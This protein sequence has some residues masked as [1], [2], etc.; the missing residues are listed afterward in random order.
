VTPP[1]AGQLS[2][3]PDIKEHIVSIRQLRARLSR[4]DAGMSLIEVIVAFTVFAVV[5]VGMAYS[6]AAMT[7]FSYDS[8]KRETASNLALAELDRVQAISDAFAV[9]NQPAQTTNVNGV[10]YTI[11]TKLT[12]VG[13]DGTT[14][15]SCGTA[16]SGTNLQYKSVNIKVS[17]AGMLNVSAVR[18]DSALAPASRV[19]D[20]SFGTILVN[21]YG[22]DGT[23]RSAVTV[24][25]TPKTGGAAITE[26]IDPTDS[27]GC[28]YVLKVSPGTYTIK[29]SKASYMETKQNASFSVDKPVTAG[30][31][32]T[33]SVEY[34]EQASFGLKYAA[35]VTSPPLLPSGLST[36]YYYGPSTYVSTSTATP[37]KLYPYLNGYSG[38]AG[39]ALSCA[40]SDPVAWP[41]SGSL[42]AGERGTPVAASPGGNAN[43]SVPMGVVSAKMTASGTLIATQQ[44]S[45]P[46]GTPT[47]ATPATLT[48]GAVTS[49]TTYSVALPYGTWKL[50]VKNGT[51]T[52]QITTGITVVGSAIVIDDATGVLGKN[53]PGNSTVTAGV[54]TLDPRGPVS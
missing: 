4:D 30:N 7:R 37:I 2:I 9:T 34:D 49:G 11:D 29:I 46:A 16:G 51:T 25:V 48:V 36:T 8:E 5:T 21:V 44:T 45:G 24:T 35:N 17:W 53:L 26:T 6:M 20:P 43:I 33:V 42:G 54:I 27:D 52:T 13:A 40:A 19:N 32:T 38:I 39:D 12:W 22:F 10:N 41:A 47:C 50:S 3:H 15:G 1:A 28:T 31:T 14:A 23:A 18:L